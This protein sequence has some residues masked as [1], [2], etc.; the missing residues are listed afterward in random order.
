MITDAQTNF[1]SGQAI[2]SGTQ[3]STNTYDLGTARD[4][5]RGRAL[6]IYA[7]ATTTFT[8]GTSLAVNIVEDTQAS[9]ATATVI[10]TGN[11]TVEAGLTAGTR[12]MDIVLPKTSKRYIGLQY[13]SVGV[14]TA[15][16]VTAGMVMDSD[17]GVYFPANTGF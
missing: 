7:H 12:L 6:R 8:G 17:S 15:G 13:V 2:T 11:A 5:G 1:S 4:V 9:L 16:A 3:L 10:E 14:H